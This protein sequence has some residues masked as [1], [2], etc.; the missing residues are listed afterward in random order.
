MLTLQSNTD[1]GPRKGTLRGVLD[2][3][4]NHTLGRRVNSETLPTPFVIIDA[5]T[6]WL[7]DPRQLELTECQA[8][9]DVGLVT[10]QHCC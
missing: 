6:P 3:R 5:V 10:V 1:T 4:V 9:L 8:G 7:P 2:R